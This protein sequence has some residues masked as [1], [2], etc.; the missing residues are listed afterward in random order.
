[1]KRLLS[2][3]RSGQVPGPEGLG[4]T[5]SDAQPPAPKARP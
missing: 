3:V 4:P 2:H 5:A 1:M